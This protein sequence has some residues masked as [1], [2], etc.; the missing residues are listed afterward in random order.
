MLVLPVGHQSND[1]KLKACKHVQWWFCA[2]CMH[3]YGTIYEVCRRK[4]L[5]LT[6]QEQWSK[7]KSEFKRSPIS[8]C[9][10]NRCA[11]PS[12]TQYCSWAGI[13]ASCVDGH[14]SLGKKFQKTAHNWPQ[15]LSARMMMMMNQIW[16]WQKHYL[17]QHQTSLWYRKLFLEIAVFS[18]I[19]P[20]FLGNRTQ[21][22]KHLNYCDILIHYLLILINLECIKQ[23]VI[24]ES[25]WV[26]RKDRVLKITKQVTPA[27]PITI[28]LQTN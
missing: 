6:K 8:R 2:L 26:G 10:H 7:K 14:V 15:D 1:T 4:Q 25:D 22:Y 9:N 13:L 21:K 27:F 24:I 16:D 23:N 3:F 28:E 19:I 12:T 17:L 5:K 18:C 11:L 20:K